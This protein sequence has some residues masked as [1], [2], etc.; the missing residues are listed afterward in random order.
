[1]R[2]FVS[3]QDY[4][5]RNRQYG[6]RDGAMVVAENEHQN[7]KWFNDYDSLDE[8]LSKESQMNALTGHRWWLHSALLPRKH[9]PSR[10]TRSVNNRR[11]S[12]SWAV[13]ANALSMSY[14]DR[15]VNR[16]LAVWLKILFF[17]A[18]PGWRGPASGQKKSELRAKAS[19]GP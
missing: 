19:W 15:T 8:W 11:T 12:S 9:L 17:C 1:M 10:S 3:D 16:M 5:S 7:H 13:K 4:V 14:S 6:N 2:F 18:G